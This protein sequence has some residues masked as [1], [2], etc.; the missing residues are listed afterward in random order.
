VHLGLA[1]AIP[2]GLVVV[3]LRDADHLTI[4]ELHEGAARM[5]AAARA[6]KLSPDDMTGS[7]FSISNLGMFGVEHF[8]AIIN[9]GESAILAVGSAVRTP[10]VIGDGIGIRSLMRL[11]LSADHRLVDGE[12]AARFLDDLRRRMES[13]ESLRS[14]RL[15][16]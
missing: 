4:D 2:N 10:V 7:T 3:V 6:G 1:V 16:L 13:P 14:K 9:P 15:D 12:I 11:S 5:A 8:T